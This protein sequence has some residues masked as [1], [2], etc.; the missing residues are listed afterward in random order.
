MAQSLAGEEWVASGNLLHDEGRLF[1]TVRVMKLTKHQLDQLD[2]QTL[3]EYVHEHW[4]EIRQELGQMLNEL[5]VGE[6]TP[7]RTDQDGGGTA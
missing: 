4:T 6:P 5:K 7:A 1:H 3:G 2:R